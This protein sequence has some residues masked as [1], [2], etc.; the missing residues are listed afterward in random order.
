METITAGIRSHL[1]TCLIAPE[2]L[3]SLTYTGCAMTHHA[4]G[5]PSCPAVQIPS[6]PMLLSANLTD[7]SSPG[8]IEKAH[9]ADILALK[10]YSNQLMELLQNYQL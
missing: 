8:E 9:V 3:T 5:I 10:N 2:D 1:F 4:A 6:K 7:E